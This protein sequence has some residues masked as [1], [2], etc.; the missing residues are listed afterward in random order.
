M[1]YMAARLYEHRSTRYRPFISLIRSFVLRLPLWKELFHLAAWSGGGAGSPGQSRLQEAECWTPLL[2]RRT[3]EGQEEGRNWLN[4]SSPAMQQ[5]TAWLARTGGPLLTRSNLSDSSAG[6]AVWPAAGWQQS[7]QNRGTLVR[8]RPAS[9]PHPSS[10]PL[11]II[12]RKHTIGETSIVAQDW[13]LI[14]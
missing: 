10:S 8:P 2:H 6:S 12:Q 4:S 13:Y 5:C 14:M 9:P 7:S 1:R 3:R 11:H